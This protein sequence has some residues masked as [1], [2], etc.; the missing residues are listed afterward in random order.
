LFQEQVKLLAE[1]FRV[2]SIEHS[3]N[4]QNYSIG[5]EIDLG[6]WAC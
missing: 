3:L 5:A 4:R 1:F 2:L 6:L